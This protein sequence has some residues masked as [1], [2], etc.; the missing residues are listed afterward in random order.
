[1][2]NDIDSK[3]CIEFYDG[4]FGIPLDSS[5]FTNVAEFSNIV[6]FIGI[7][8]QWVLIENHINRHSWLIS[9][10]LENAQNSKMV[11]M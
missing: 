5:T 9:M 3:K 4:H 10:V 2:T 6:S 8:Q 11:I 1:M 7:Q